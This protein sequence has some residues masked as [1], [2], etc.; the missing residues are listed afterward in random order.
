MRRLAALTLVAFLLAGTALASAGC[1]VQPVTLG[2]VAVAGISN[3]S[4]AVAPIAQ[5]MAASLRREVVPRVYMSEGQLIEALGNGQ[6]DTAIISAFAYAT[7][8]DR[9]GAN[10]VLSGQHGNSSELRYELLTRPDTG[11]SVPAQMIGKAVALPA[12]EG[13]PEQRYLLTFLKRFGAGDKVASASGDQAALNALF[14]RTADVV[15]V[16]YGFRDSVRATVPDIDSR[17]RVVWISERVPYEA[18]AVA[19]APRVSPA[20]LSR[21]WQDIAGQDAFK[22]ALRSLFGV[23]GFIP[24]VDADYAPAREAIQALGITIR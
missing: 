11:I 14:G 8:H 20:D 19:K 6:C 16:S 18:A 2:I 17:I 12:T 13:T 21:A 15:A 4:E 1:G 23:D 7:A 9:Y 5:A 10:V 24:A 22:S 3:L